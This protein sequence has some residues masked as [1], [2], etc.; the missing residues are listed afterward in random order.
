MLGTSG[1]A[2]AAANKGVTAEGTG[3]VRCPSS[4]VVPS[5]T[6]NLEASRSKGIVQGF[7]QITDPTFNV[8]NKGGS[9]D[10]GSMNG[11]SFNLT[12]VI[13]FDRC[14]AFTQPVPVRAV[15][16]GDCG[17]GVLITYS[18]DNGETGSFVGNAVCS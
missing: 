2:G 9:I 8:V 7:V 12:A 5:T 3:S 18:D 13:N 6:I 16:S 10:G 14:G 11:S 17:T 1:V 15:I 4:Q